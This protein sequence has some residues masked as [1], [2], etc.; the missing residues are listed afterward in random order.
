MATSSGSTPFDVAII[1]GGLI[2]LQVALGLRNRNIP[3]TVYEQASEIQEIGAGIGLTFGNEEC[4]GVIDPRLPA[5]MNEVGFRTTRGIGVVNASN[6]D[7]DVTLRPQDNLFDMHIPE[8]GRILCQRAELMTQ[9]VKLLP[10]DCIKL[11]KRLED[12]KCDEDNLILTFTDGA[13][14]A[15]DAGMLEYFNFIL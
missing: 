11:G 6:P 3:V 9:L 15:T 14:V 12:I 5:A 7:E 8:K 1:G 13:K 10:S 2:G 4:M